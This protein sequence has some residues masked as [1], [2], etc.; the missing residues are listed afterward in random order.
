MI[1]YLQVEAIRLQGIEHVL[2]FTVTDDNTILFRSYK[3]LLKKSG[4]KT[5]RI[6]LTEIGPSMDLSIRRT[7]I[8]SDDLYKLS[9][10]QPRQLKTFKK[11]NIDRDELGVTRG[12]VHVGRQKINSIQTRKIKGLRKTPEEKK[13]KRQKKKA[14]IKQSKIS[15]STATSVDE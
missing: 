9:R 10:K 12:R 5:P 8:A 13:A 3:I 1:L 2:S 7:K 11:K 6:E 14:D 4:L 15:Q